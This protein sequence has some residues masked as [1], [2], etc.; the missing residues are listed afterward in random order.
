MLFCTTHINYILRP[1]GWRGEMNLKN[2]SISLK[3]YKHK[4]MVIHPFLTILPIRFS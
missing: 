3:L 2:C 1:R 4:L